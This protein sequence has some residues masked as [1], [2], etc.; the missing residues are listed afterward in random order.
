MV[1]NCYSY[2][3]IILYFILLVGPVIFG[4]DCWLGFPIS[5]V[6]RRVISKFNKFYL[7]SFSPIIFNLGQF[8]LRWEFWGSLTQLKEL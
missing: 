1:I 8:G 6:L 4:K 5:W 2:V 3:Y 7:G